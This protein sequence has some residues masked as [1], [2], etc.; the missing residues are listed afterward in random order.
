MELVIKCNCG[1]QPEIKDGEIE[2]TCLCGRSYSRSFGKVG[3]N[4]WTQTSLPTMRGSDGACWCVCRE[5]ISNYGT[6]AKCGNVVPP[7]RTR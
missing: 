5:P 2:T 1:R 7:R 4:I 3:L 6:C